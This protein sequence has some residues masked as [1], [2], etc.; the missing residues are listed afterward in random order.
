[1]ISIKSMLLAVLNNDKAN[2][3]FLHDC[4]SGA[5]NKSRDKC[6]ELSFLTKE[7]SVN[8]VAHSTGKIGV[9]LWVDREEWRRIEN[10]GK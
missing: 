5:K 9:V 3:Q 7:L 8:D 10:G 2:V 4:L 6:V 1:M